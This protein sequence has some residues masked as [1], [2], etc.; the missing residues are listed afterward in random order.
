MRKDLPPVKYPTGKEV[1]AT[2]TTYDGRNSVIYVSN[3]VN[4][5]FHFK[6]TPK[7]FWLTLDEFDD[8]RKK[9]MEES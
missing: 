4:G 7:E 2:I 5:V 1:R 9:M 8:I 3:E 6:S